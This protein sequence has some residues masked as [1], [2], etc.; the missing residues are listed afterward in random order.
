M[1]SEQHSEDAGQPKHHCWAREEE[2]IAFCLQV[3]CQTEP[4]QRVD[5]LEVSVECLSP[6][7]QQRIASSGIEPGVSHRRSQ[8]G[9]GAGSPPPSPN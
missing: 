6:R 4:P 5:C 7:T 2:F 9:R 1:C 8:G 3:F